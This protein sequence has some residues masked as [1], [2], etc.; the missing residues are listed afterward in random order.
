MYSDEKYSHTASAAGTDTVS[1]GR[2]LN[3][4][5]NRV[6]GWMFAGLAATGAIS[7]YLGT[8]QA[9]K[10]MQYR[11]FYWLLVLAEFGVV[12][13]LSAGIRKFSSM[14]ASLLFMI[15][16]VLN[17][18]TLS[19]IF[20]AYTYRFFVPHDFVGT[21]RMRPSAASNTF[22]SYKDTF[23]VSLQIFCPTRFCKAASNASKCSV[24]CIQKL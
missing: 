24:E 22:K 3:S 16:A 12:I 17:G 11:S 1:Q 18:V 19:W 20:I 8:Y 9:E 15:F 23:D 14:A 7:W 2:V 21:H 5:I 6:F 4:F 10:V 13:A